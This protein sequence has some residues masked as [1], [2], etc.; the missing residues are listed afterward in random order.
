MLP[1]DNLKQVIVYTDSYD[2][3]LLERFLTYTVNYI[4]QKDLK[5]D[6]EVHIYGDAEQLPDN[7]RNNFAN[8]CDEV[9]YHT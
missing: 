6:V 9:I 7:I 8:L 4:G 2:F 1:L 3:H 5:K